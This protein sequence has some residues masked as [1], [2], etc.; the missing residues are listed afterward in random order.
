MTQEVEIC[1][2]ETSLTPEK[3][4]EYRLL[5]YYQLIETYKS[6]E[7]SFKLIKEKELEIYTVDT[8][9]IQGNIIVPIVSFNDNLN[10]FNEVETIT[11]PV[12]RIQK[13]IT[14][15][16]EKGSNIVEDKKYKILITDSRQQNDDSYNYPVFDE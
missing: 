5:E 13:E 14:V 15:R 12:D 4:E 9:K 16:L 3:L 11:I 1:D 2:F 6:K 7:L 10:K 8:S